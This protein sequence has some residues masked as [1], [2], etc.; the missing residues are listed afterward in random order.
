MLYVDFIRDVEQ[1][2]QQFCSKGVKA[3]KCHGN[4]KIEG[5]ER[6]FYREEFPVLVATESFELGVDNPN[7]TQLIRVGSPRNLG[8]LLQEFGRGGRKPG[9]SAN[10]ILLFNECIDDKH[11]AVWLKFSLNSRT[12]SH[13]NEAKKVDITNFPIQK[14]KRLLYCKMI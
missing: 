2:V 9:A 5:R 6:H 10:A 7:I 13:T 1:V 14:S 3:A 11:L 12:N 4:M 8:V